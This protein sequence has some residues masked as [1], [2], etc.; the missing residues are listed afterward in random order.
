MKVR[1]SEVGRDKRS[2][3]SELADLSYGELLRAVKKA[4]ALG[5]RGIDFDFNDETQR[6]LIWVGGF[7]PVGAFEVLPD[8]PSPA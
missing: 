7:R 6:G 5:S 8:A 2:W 1:F 4:G 3:E